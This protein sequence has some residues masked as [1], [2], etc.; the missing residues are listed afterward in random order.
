M[1]K[2][3]VCSQGDVSLDQFGS[4]VDD[5]PHHAVIHAEGE[6]KQSSSQYHGGHREPRSTLVA[7]EISIAEAKE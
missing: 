3:P 2:V 7:P 6:N 4:I 5:I 1:L